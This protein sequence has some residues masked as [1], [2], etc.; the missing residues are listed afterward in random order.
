MTLRNLPNS[1]KEVIQ[2]GCLA[3]DQLV[4][5]GELMTGE[6]SEQEYTG[7]QG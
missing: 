5:G 6:S 7:R 1:S 4:S 2:E 3:E